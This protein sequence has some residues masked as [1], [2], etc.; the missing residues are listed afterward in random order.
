MDKAG[1]KTRDIKFY[2]GKNGSMVT[3]HSKEARAFAKYLEAMEHVRSY[4]VG[5]PIDPMRLQMISKVDIRGEYF[6][7]QWETDFYVLF[8]DGTAA[9]REIAA[10]DFPSKRAE[11]ERLELSR[12]YWSSM[13]VT[14][15]KIVLMG[16]K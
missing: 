3:V 13:G 9:V 8:D 14:D 6:E 7:Q 2:S 15:W 10:E 4:E 12:R 1:K 16:G 11:V 5:K